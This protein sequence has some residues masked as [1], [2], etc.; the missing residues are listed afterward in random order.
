MN[1]STTPPAKFVAVDK[2]IKQGLTTTV[3]RA[4]STNMAK[5]IANAL[6]EYTPDRRGQ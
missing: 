4:T 3:A 6:N 2:D 5:R 1:E